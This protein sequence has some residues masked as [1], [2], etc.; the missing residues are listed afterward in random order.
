MEHENEYG[1]SMVATL[2]LIW[3]EGFMAP[4]GE[5][6]VTKMVEGLELD[7]RRV[8]DLGCGIGGPACILA[9]KYG[10][11]VV[12]T[13][14]EPPLI[15]RARRRAAT[16]GLSD[17][18]EF[19]VVTPGR[20]SFDDESFDLVI[21]SG[22]VTQTADKLGILRECLRVLK[23]GGTFSGYDWM[24][25]EGEYSEDMRYWFEMEGLTYAM[26]TPRGQQA[27][28]REAGFDE[29]SVVDGS[30]WYRTEVRKEYERLRTRDFSSLVERVGKESADH[31]VENW[32]AMVVVCE[33]GEMLQVYSRA[34]APA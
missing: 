13:D 30:A 33:K 10:A 3:G 18:T 4:G 9:G 7:G 25:S 29:V 12:A 32:R 14:L 31:F 22:G 24:K 23:P 27:T 20:L 11:H 15:E 19:E 26:E 28:L 16:L 6:N 34:R 8:L 1:D 5:G 2:E 17:Q 21:S